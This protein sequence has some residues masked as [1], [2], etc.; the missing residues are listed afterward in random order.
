[1]L[2]KYIFVRLI[3][4]VNIGTYKTRENVYSASF[5]AFLLGKYRGY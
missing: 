3:S 4:N 5:T 1:M 2:K